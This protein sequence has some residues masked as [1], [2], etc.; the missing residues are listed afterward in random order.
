[1][2]SAWTIIAL[3]EITFIS[4][5]LRPKIS[6]TP[7]SLKI[8]EIYILPIHTLQIMDWLWNYILIFSLTLRFY[9]FWQLIA[10]IPFTAGVRT[11]TP[12]F[13]FVPECF[14]IFSCSSARSVV[15]YRAQQS[16]LP[17]KPSQSQTLKIKTD[18]F[19]ILFLMIK[20][21]LIFPKCSSL[22][23]I[24]L[25]ILLKKRNYGASFQ[26]DFWLKW[27]HKTCLLNLHML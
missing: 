4:P 6:P 22:F 24:V 12:P 25:N 26:K 17:L 19:L 9:V 10:S 23:K 27:M 16:P 5:L 14:P 18:E 7:L 11:Y 21:Y 3:D 1:M 20:N 15:D 13:C 8:N 2:Q